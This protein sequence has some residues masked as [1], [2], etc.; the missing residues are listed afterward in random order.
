MSFSDIILSFMSDAHVIRDTIFLLSPAVKGNNTP[1]TMSLEKTY[2]DIVKIG[3]GGFGLVFSATHRVT[4]KRR[5]IK[6][7]SFDP[8]QRSEAQ[9][10]VQ[11]LIL[12]SDHRHEN[13][14]L[15][16]TCWIQDLEAVT[17]F[18]VKNI[19]ESSKPT[20][21]ANEIICIVME[22][23]DGSLLDHLKEVNRQ[24]FTGNKVCEPDKAIQTMKDT[25]K[26]ILR[27]G[28]CYPP[29]AEA[30][31]LP[32]CVQICSGINFLHSL[33]IAHRDLKPG[34][35]LFVINN[36]GSKTFKIA[37][38]GLAKIIVFSSRNTKVGTPFYSSPEQ[39]KSE[40]SGRSSD[41]YSLGIILLE[42]LYPFDINQMYGR[43]IEVVHWLRQFK[44]RQSLPTE[45]V[46]VYPQLSE[47][48]MRMIKDDRTKRPLI[49]EV[50]QVLTRTASPQAADAA[51]HGEA[52]ANHDPDP[53]LVRGESKKNWCKLL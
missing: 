34:N 19:L 8:G 42:I 30:E 13:I 14:V 52:A 6:C 37:D 25:G 51:D 44:E 1:I 49:R 2:T 43:R 28:K 47:M 9:K 11:H 3:S 18:G 7:S 10:E 35:I 5:A 29:A 41:I 38:F 45:F 24:F 15:Y 53:R 39:L 22:L 46:H 12:L 21:H 48:I 4:G 50:L 36:D 16:E 26:K 23:C 33:N 31:Q 20:A 32:I 27:H 40:K 17:T